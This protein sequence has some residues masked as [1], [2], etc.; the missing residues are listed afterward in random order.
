MAKIDW[1]VHSPHEIRMALKEAPKVAGPWVQDFYPLGQ[2]WQRTAG[3]RQRIVAEVI[4]NRGGEAPA[5]YVEGF[6]DYDVC[7]SIE[8]GKTM[9]DESLR[10]AGWLL[11]DEPLTIEE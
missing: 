2:K 3:K 5:F 7:T 11:D 1:T 8:D 6:D 10:A 4:H 9:A